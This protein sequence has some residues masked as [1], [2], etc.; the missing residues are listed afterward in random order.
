MNRSESSALAKNFAKT[1]LGLLIGV[2]IAIFAVRATGVSR[3]GILANLA[4]ASPWKIALG[5]LGGFVLSAS[6][7][8][9]WRAI[10]NGIH[11]VRFFTVFQ[12][13]LVG[14]AANSILPGRLGDLVRIEFVSAVT[15]IP[16][17]KVLATGIT[18]LWFDKMG[19]ILTFGIATFVAPMP[20]WVLKAMGVMGGLLLIVGGLLFYLS[21]GKTGDTVL[22]RFREGLDQPNFGR[23]CLQQL[24]LSPLSWVW[25]TLLIL[26]VAGAF[27]IP[28]NFAQA[29]AVLTAF[30]VSM[31]VPI[32][33]NAGMFEIAATFALKEFGVAPDQALAFSL[34]YHLMLLIPGVLAGAIFFSQHGGK[35]EL[36]RALGKL[37][38]PK[39]VNP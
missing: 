1:A 9:R 6:Q 2:G 38:Q 3:E 5:M 15:Q 24:W 31:V 26:F 4:V 11:P 30:N 29:F 22:G 10:L 18:D 8:V 33:A 32:P 19:W 20:D 21:R 23:L 39:V 14:Y 36:V 35:F 37:R 17:S 7:A 25:E 12:S 27:G 28:L 13:K 34:I 16:R